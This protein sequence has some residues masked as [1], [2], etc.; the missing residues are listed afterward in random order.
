[1]SNKLYVIV[2]G[3]GELSAVPL[4]LRRLLYEKFERYDFSTISPINARGRGN[5]TRDGG[6]ERLLEYTRRQ[7]DCDGVLVLFDAEKDD[8]DCPPRIAYVFAERAAALGLPF[9]V[10]IVCAVC[11]YE[12]WF[13][14]SD[15]IADEYF[16]AVYPDNPDEECSAKGWINRHLRT[17]ATYR[18]TIDQTDMSQL[19]ELD[20][21]HDKSRSFR[22][23]VDALTELLMAIDGGM[24]AVTPIADE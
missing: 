16:T 9:P 2:E 3:D 5:L 21:L 19:L 4:L 13:L 1:M 11:E 15:T 6:L 7:P 10:S 8:V 12:S 24:K 17:Q 14:Y 23:L 20:E 22:R 18:E